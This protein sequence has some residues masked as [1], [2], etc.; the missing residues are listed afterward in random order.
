MILLSRKNWT[1]QLLNGMF[2]W[3]KLS[4]IAK[5]LSDRWFQHKIQEYKNYR[6]LVYRCKKFDT[7]FRWAPKNAKQLIEWVV[8]LYVVL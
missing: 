2:N 3:A 6:S 8:R 5:Q 1:R 7:F 4:I